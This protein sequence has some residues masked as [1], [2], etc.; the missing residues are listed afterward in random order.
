[1]FRWIRLVRYFNWVTIQKTIACVIQK[2]LTGLAAEM[3]F[4]GM[5]GLFPAIIAV[6]TAITL[7]GQSI[8]STLVSLAV[9]FAGIIP[10]QVWTLL[11][12]F[13]DNIRSAEGKN[14]FSISSIATVWIISGVLSAAMN[15]LDIIHQVIKENKRSYLQ[16]KAIAVS[17]TILTL[18]FLIIACFFTVGSEILYYSWHFNKAGIP[19]CCPLGKYL[20]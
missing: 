13:I 8:E 20:A 6:L 9:H 4:H 16:T 2:R 1:M 7:F 5:L 19:Y 3:A 10:I 14:W 12:D 11:L 18:I 15:A 17:L